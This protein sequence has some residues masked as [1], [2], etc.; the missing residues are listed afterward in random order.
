MVKSPKSSNLINSPKIRKKTDM[1]IV[2]KAIKQARIEPENK[3]QS[4]LVVLRIFYRSNLLSILFDPI[5]KAAEN[6]ALHI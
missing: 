6:L 1:K 2:M 3:S 5:F 4:F